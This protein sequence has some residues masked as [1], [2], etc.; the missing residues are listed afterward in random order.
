MPSPG[1]VATVRD[2]SNSYSRSSKRHRQSSSSR[3]RSPIP[4]KSLQKHDTSVRR[5][6][7]SSR[8]SSLASNTGSRKTSKTKDEVTLSK[9]STNRRDSSSS[10]SSPSSNSSR[11]HN[12]ELS[13]KDVAT[14]DNQFA[15]Q[16]QNVDLFGKTGGAYIPPARLRQMQA[17]ITDKNTDAYQRI[18]WEALKKSIHGLIN[19]VNV[20]NI[21]QVVR[22]L[23]MEN[24][25]RGRGLLVKSLITSQMASPTF[26]HIFAAL[27]AIIN[28]KFPQIGELLLKRLINEFRKAFRRN[29]K[30]RCLTTGR[31]LAHLV[32]QKVAHELIVLELLTLLLEQTTND[33]VEV[34]VALLK[35]CGAFLSRVVPKGLAGIFDHL[36]R[37]LNES[38]CDK[39]ISYM[40]EVLLQIRRDK[41][42]DYPTVIPELDL[43]EEDDQITHTLSLLD[44]VDIEDGLNIYR[45]DSEYEANEAK[46]IEIRETFLGDENSDESGSSGSESGSE[47]SNDEEGDVQGPGEQEGGTIIDQTETN[48]VHLRRTIYLMLQSSISADEGAHRLL[49][50]KIKPGEEY[51]VASMVLDCCA[52]TRSYETRY[53]SLAQRLCRVML[54][55]G[56]KP[57]PGETKQ[58]TTQPSEPP[59]TYVAQF[60]KIFGEQYATIHRLETAKLKNVAMF[61]AHLLFT[62]SISWGVL[63]CV[64]LNERDTSSS[65]RIFLKYLFQELCSFMG[66][67]KLQ[68]RL[69][70]ETLQPFFVHLLPRNNP[71]DTRFAINFLTTIGLGGLTID[72]REHLQATKAAGEKAKLSEDVE[73]SSSDSDS[74]SSSSS[75]SESSSSDSTSS[76][77]SS[78]SSSHSSE[79]E[80]SASGEEPPQKKKRM[81]KRIRDNEPDG[82]LNEVNK[83]HSDS[84]G[85]LRVRE[86]GDRRDRHT[87]RPESKRDRQVSP[88]GGHDHRKGRRPTTPLS[89]APLK[90][91]RDSPISPSLERMIGGNDND[92]NIRNASPPAPMTNP[93]PPKDN[94]RSKRLERESSPALEKRRRYNTPTPLQDRRKEASPSILQSRHSKHRDKRL[95]SPQPPRRRR[96]V[97]P[98]SV[99]VEKSTSPR[100]S[101]QLS[102]PSNGK[103]RKEAPTPPLRRS[104][105]V[106]P[107]P[108][109]PKR[110]KPTPT[111]LRRGRFDSPPRVDKRRTGDS[112]QEKRKNLSQ[113]PPRRNRYVSPPMAPPVKENSGRSERRRISPSRRGRY[114]SPPAI[115]KKRTPSPPRRNRY[116]SPSPNANQNSTS[117]GGKQGSSSPRRSRYDLPTAPRDRKNR[118]AASPPP[119]KYLPSESSKRRK[120]SPSPLVSLKNNR[121]RTSSPLRRNRLASSSPLQEK[122]NPPLDSRKGRYDSPHKDLKRDRRRVDSRERGK[123]DRHERDASK[124]RDERRRRRR[125]DSGDAKQRGKELKG[126]SRSGEKRNRNASSSV[127]ERSPF[128]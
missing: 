69:R 71:K 81:E 115:V 11:T 49:Q 88:D 32:N 110:R 35:E 96:Q 56:E 33:S 28:T 105:Q 14:R 95:D 45:F 78:G 79:S 107:V 31:F 52:Q 62:D 2:S 55:S 102:S 7:S 39:R 72:L 121:Q 30:D 15:S 18:A 124:E 50:L 44:Q 36:R 70:D 120:V 54:F 9:K 128:Y 57:K 117:L 1:P 113:T 41:W 89:S 91:R 101:R 40:I 16:S 77:S 53:G 46:Y 98:P 6:Y 118:Y 67:A 12:K 86:N 59:R 80:S 83:H 97:S 106:S 27:I 76:T 58:Q 84:L 90:R 42:R 24:I 20:S 17:K 10:R 119:Q 21:S 19:K 99:S 92:R 100:K 126:S 116:A 29:Q 8:S 108:K 25:I 26:T 51:E 103:S 75:D 111:P 104:R 66:L 73:N 23:L 47:D 64:K 82:D 85:D 123:R 3:S 93:S 94:G 48:L 109:S 87:K 65:G 60:E 114:D 5:H 37:I 74:E 63:E 61:F 13:K 34:S 38:Q 122:L 4:R 125:D 68:A 22:Q 127:R 112:E 43:I